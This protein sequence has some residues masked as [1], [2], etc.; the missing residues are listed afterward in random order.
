VE[1]KGFARLIEACRILA[2]RGAAFDCVI[3]GSGELEAEL[4]AHVRRLDLEGRV[5]LTG[6]TLLQ[7][8]ITEFM[9]AGDV[10]VLPCVRAADGDVDGLPQMLVEAMACGLPA[11]ST[12]LAGIPDLVRHEETGLLVEPHDAAGLADAIERLM[13]DRPLAARLA[14]A[15][16]RWVE[17]RFDLATCLEPLIER[18]RR[19]VDPAQPGAAPQLT[20]RPQGRLAA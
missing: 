5:K 2:N 3:G 14:A 16:R 9:H 4:R 1:K 13:R 10:Y 12:R 18:Y 7:E 17:E 6:E 15:G 11:I 19:R 8:R 20:P